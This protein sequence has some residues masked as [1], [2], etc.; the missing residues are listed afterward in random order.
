MKRVYGT[1]FL[2]SLFISSASYGQTI[3]SAQSGPWNDPQT[4]SPQVVPT[5]ANSSSILINSGHTVNFNVSGSADQITVSGTLVVDAGVNLTLA[6]G[7]GNEITVDPGGQL[8]NNG[9]IVFGGIPNRTVL[10]NGT[11]NNNGT[12][13]GVLAAKLNFGP[14]SSYNHQFENGGVIPAA[15]WN[16]SS[17]VNIVG[18]TSGNDTPPVGLNQP[19][20]NFVWNAPGQDRTVVLNSIG[21]LNININ[22]DFRIESTGGDALF[23]SAGGPG[24]T[25]NIG[26]D[27]QITGGVLGWTT[28]DSGP[29][30]INIGGNLEITSGYFQIADDVDVTANVAGGFVLS[31]DGMVDFAASG[32]ITNLNL[33]GN[34][35]HTGGEMYVNGGAGNVNFIGASTKLFDSEIDP[36]GPVN[37]SVASLST[38]DII[39]ESFVGGH[40]N[41]TLNGILRLGSTHPSGALQTGDQAGNLR[42]VGTRT[43]ATNATVIYAGDGKQ[44]IGNGFPSGSDVNLSI[45]NINGVELS[46]SLDIVALRQLNLANGNIIIGTQTLTINGIVTG[47]GGIIGGSSSKMVIGGT[48]DFGT[49]TFSG[50]NQLEDFTLNRSGSGL[51]TLGDDLTI[52]GTFTHTNGT[53]AIG[54][55]TLRISGD[56]EASNGI[57]SVTE[58]STVII[59]GEGVLPSDV[60][61]AGSDLGTLTVNRAN[62]TFPTTSS[63]AIHNLE[64]FDGVLD[65]G[66]G[67][68]IAAG[69]TITRNVGG[70][71]STSPSNTTAV[72]NVAYG[73]GAMTTGP[74]LPGNATALQNLTKSGGNTLTLASN[75]TVNGTL[76][77][78]S[79]SF[80]AGSNN[81]EL[82]GDF[83]SNA[84]STLTS[85]TV[86]FPNTTLI[87][88]NTQP[89][90]GNVVISGVVT[91]NVNYR[92]NGNLD[93][94]GTL[95][96]G[97]GSVTFGGTTLIS[98]GGVN[99]FNV[100]TIATSSTLTGPA[101]GSISVAGNFL[102]NGTFTHNSGTVVFNGASS[103]GGTPPTFNNI[104][105][106]GALNGPSTLTLHGNLIINGTFTHGNNRTVVFNGTGAQR[107]DRASG[108]SAVI[109]FFNITVDKGSN[110]FRVESTVPGTVFRVGNKFEVVQNGSNPTDVDFDGVSGTGTL[111]LRSTS[112]RTAFIPA[113]PSGASL[114]GNITVERFISNIAGVR[115]YRYLAPAVVGS[116]IAD[117]QGEIAITGQFSDP[118]TTGNPA[119]PS[120]YRYVED[121]GGGWGNRYQVYPNNDA[122]PASSFPLDNGRGYAVY[123]Y[124]AGTPTL[125]T[126]GTLRTGDVVVNLT[127]TGSEPDAA[128][129]NLVGNPYASP[130]NWNLVS[131]P[132][133][134]SSTISLKDNVD[135]AGPGA[136][137][138]VY[139]VQNGP[140]IGDFDGVIASGQAFWVETSANTSITF[141][142]AHKASE[143]NPVLVREKTLANVLRLYIEGN[144]RNDES[145]I[146]LHDEATEEADLR[147]DAKK[148]I[149]DF[150]NLYTFFEGSQTRFAINGLNEIGCSKTFKIGLTD[151]NSDSVN[152]VTP[153]AY[154]LSFSQFETFINEYRFLLVDKFSNEVINLRQQPEYTFNVSADPETAGEERFELIISLPSFAT[155]NVVHYAD[156]V[157]ED[158]AAGITIEGTDPRVSY[159][160][161]NSLGQAVSDVAQGNG[162]ALVLDVSRADLAAGLNKLIVFAS[163]GVCEA[164]PLE[165]TVD[166][167][168][169]AMETAVISLVDGGT[170]LTTNISGNV[171]WYLDGELIP[172]AVDQQITPDKS[173]TY[174]VVAGVPGCQTSAYYEFSV[175]GLGEESFK[176]SIEVYPNPA[177]ERVTVELKDMAPAIATLVNTVGATAGTADFVQSEGLQKAEFDLTNAPRGL[178]LLRIQQGGKNISFKVIK[179]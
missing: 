143:Q 141:S 130:I 41:F 89:V 25:A 171:Q 137:T 46:T 80:A 95:N 153:G 48:G 166:L 55:N 102:N 83:V 31:G 109:D 91:P 19:F 61:F 63:I 155:N 138:F 66:A 165:Q 86:T 35:T 163:N 52:L 167:N 114:T 49:L 43:Y 12:F 135:N 117:W 125:D 108:S 176:N 42:I 110:T 81:I 32:A 88:G 78:M 106:T 10:I 169:A 152:V 13:N 139:Y 105:V 151:I 161:R 59:D 4:W 70:S 56:Y 154:T 140:P 129:F 34:Y 33:Q 18:Y 149:N 158:G 62:E 38:L 8:T 132:G 124:D 175:T 24:G 107:L 87:S 170:A 14:N 71:M 146:W 94:S 40:G 178:Y 72:Y 104:T 1:V 22:G 74:E 15:T 122:L 157:C 45:D 26:G 51:V 177:A 116:T 36:L 77:L 115:S 101:S 3:T 27:L 126:R 148:R 79:G 97:T 134:V 6:N 112:Q 93:N 111:V 99:A 2:I 118:T 30:T 20:G 7:A 76:S 142:E 16:A 119:S 69:G 92:I 173:G 54:T 150:L 53:L 37:Y 65:N 98:G 179:E 82:R 172:G 127:A 58:Q 29:S 11:L 147:F 156:V 133:V 44:F 144:G 164:L 47:T 23:Y 128:G 9:E 39:G 96:A 103:I 123:M 84:A 160:V 168:V 57:L 17:T 60:S 64:L 100:L 121:A 131:L 145:V 90:F 113:V 85:A 68:S 21:P 162:D 73:A 75:I 120:L 174:Q 28:G 67:L 50:T 5:A 136:G 159:F